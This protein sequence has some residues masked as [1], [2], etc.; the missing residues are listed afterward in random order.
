MKPFCR[1]VAVSGIL[2][3]LAF[4]PSVLT[5]SFAQA[6][7][8]DVQALL[9]RINR[10]EADLNN[11][12]RKV[13]QGQ[14]VPAP[15]LGG[16]T[17][18]GGASGEAAALLSARIDALE[19][20]QRQATGRM[21]EVAFKVDQLSS[22]LDKLVLD[23]DFRLSEIERRLN[24][25]AGLGGSA[26]TEAV[27]SQTAPEGSD[28][29]Q[30]AGAAPASGQSGSSLAKGPQLLGTLRVPA[31]GGSAVATTAPSAPVETA[32]TAVAATPP[33]SAAPAEQYNYAISLIRKDDY[34]G[35]EQAFTQFLEG[36]KDHALAGN[37]QYWLGE[38]HYVRGD[39]PNAASAFL[40]GYQTYPKNSKAADNLLKLAMTLGRMEQTEEACVTFQQLDKQFTTLPARLKRIA[41]RE[42]Q[43]FGCS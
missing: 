26:G 34:A 21:E 8:S 30:T 22:R 6:Q 12:Q 19:Q 3:A 1:T 17:S 27:T 39:Y 16:T 29:A 25:D 31:D 7:S 42:K 10:L 23:V 14:N 4:F 35:A 9:D 41:N 18:S 37:A 32:D 40:N 28:Q 38:T 13:F 5:S 2:V 20:E 11:V 43:K 33:A 24:G 15:S 36:N